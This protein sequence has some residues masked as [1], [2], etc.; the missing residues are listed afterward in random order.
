MYYFVFFLALKCSCLFIGVSRFKKY[1]KGQLVI[2]DPAVKD[3]TG[4]PFST[5][6]W[7][8]KDRFWLYEKIDMETFPSWN[9]FL[10]YKVSAKRGDHCV[11][12]QDHGFPERLVFYVIENPEI[13]FNVYTILTQGKAVQVLGCDLTH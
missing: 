9:D 7:H 13:D 10:G 4:I 5:C 12:L 11:I 3:L 8:K 1:E 2:F 6:G